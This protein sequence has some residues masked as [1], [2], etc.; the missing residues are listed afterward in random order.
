MSEENSEMMHWKNGN[1]EDG[2]VKMEYLIW[3]CGYLNLVGKF[4]QSLDDLESALA[5]RRPVLAHDQAEHDQRDELT[6]VGLGAG[7]PD[8]RAGVDVDPADGLTGNAGADGVGDAEDECPALFAVPQGIQR[9][10]R[11]P[12]K[13]T[14]K[15]RI[16]K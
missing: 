14:P 8:L 13:N 3:R 12:C 4:A 11:F 2:M 6:G 1:G 16:F 15:V 7:H 5:Q 10:R 9:V